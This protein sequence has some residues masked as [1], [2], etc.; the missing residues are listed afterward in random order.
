[1]TKLE[2][3]LKEYCPNGVEYKKLSDITSSINIGVNPRRFFTLNPKDADC[4]YVTVRELNGLCGVKKYDKTDLISKEAVGIIQSR[5]KIEKGDLLFSNTGTVG[6][7]ALVSETPKDWG[8]NEGIY[9]I[10]PIKEI[11]ESRFLYYY[12]SSDLAY[13]EYSTKFTGST[14][15]HITQKALSELQIPL[16]ALPVQREIVRVLDGFTLYSQE[17]T[18]ELTARCK[19]YEYYKQLLLEKQTH[20]EIKHITD[21]ALVKARVGWQ[22][23][24]T[25]EYLS[26]GDYYLI[27]GTDFRNGLI[28]FSKCVYVSKD[29]FEMDENIIVHKDDILITKD[30]TL[31]KVAFLGEEPTKPST[32]NSGIFRIK[33]IDKTVL[34]RYMFHYFTSKYF[35]DFVEGVKTGSTV[36]HLTQQGLVSLDIPVPSLE[37]QERIVN[38]L[39]NFDK[40]CSDLKIGLPAEIE[41]RQE[42]YEYYRDKLLTFDNESATIL[43]R[44]TDRQTDR[45]G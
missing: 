25:A 8:V 27:T 5:A 23:L 11:V 20:I 21:I 30:G 33:I 22:R 7:L 2:E 18:A 24:T 32:L 6:K 1:M 38:V 17:L 19:Q 40:I 13:K 37:V 34:P 44:Q 15:K 16:P 26:K 12:L 4:F 36:P 41:K 3:L 42:Q 10:K 35:T 45:Q 9:V 31:G 39:D 14:L 28:D 29:R 43:Y